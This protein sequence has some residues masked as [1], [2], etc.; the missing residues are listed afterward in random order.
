MSR[1]AKSAVVFLAGSLVAAAAFAQQPALTP[2]QMKVVMK[3]GPEGA[4]TYAAVCESCHGPPNPNTPSRTA[5]L[6]MSAEQIY[7]ALTVGKMKYAGDTITDSQKRS[8]SMY[9]TGKILDAP[10]PPE[11]PPVEASQPVAPSDQ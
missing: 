3:A 11:A 8:V 2:D 4:R 10:P 5:L 6:A 1:T 7:E 9:L